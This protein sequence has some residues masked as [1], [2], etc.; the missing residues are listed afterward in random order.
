VSEV[1]YNIW[2]V[3]RLKGRVDID[4][5]KTRELKRK[6]GCGSLFLNMDDINNSLNKIE[7]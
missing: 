3:H 7:N 4:W 5:D 2:I 1:L 6:V